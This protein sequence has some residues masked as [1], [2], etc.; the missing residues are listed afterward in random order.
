MNGWQVSSTNGMYSTEIFME[1]ANS[2]TGYYDEMF[3]WLNGR[4]FLDDWKIKKLTACAT[5]YIYT[6]KSHQTNPGG[7]KIRETPLQ[8]G[9]NLLANSEIGIKPPDYIMQ[10]DADEA[11]PEHSKFHE[12]F[13]A[14][15]ASDS[16]CMCCNWI[17]FWNDYET[18]RVDKFASQSP[19]G[20]FFKAYDKEGLAPF[21]WRPYGGGGRPRSIPLSECWICPY[22]VRHYNHINRATRQRYVD[23][24]K[25][26]I[27]KHLSDKDRPTHYQVNPKKVTTI[28]YD[29]EITCA[30]IERQQS[31][32]R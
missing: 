28:E 14:W 30:D 32:C 21:T 22:P 5:G 15:L 1:C 3:L 6:Y 16:P 10:F 24:E 25:T 31:S 17:Y 12:Y 4:E 11:M 8:L 2:W 23:N 20:F 19:H 26:Q 18:L 29:P 9:Y 13:L 7:Y 27:L